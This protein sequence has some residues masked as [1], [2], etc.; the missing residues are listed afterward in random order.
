MNSNLLCVGL[1]GYLYDA[2][3]VSDYYA[4][5]SELSYDAGRPRLPSLG[6]SAA[7]SIHSVVLCDAIPVFGQSPTSSL[8]NARSPLKEGRTLIRLR[9]WEEPNQHMPLFYHLSD[10]GTPALHSE[11]R[12]GGKTANSRDTR[13][14]GHDQLTVRGMIGFFSNS[15][16]FGAPTQVDAFVKAVRVTDLEIR[17]GL[18]EH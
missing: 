11:R 16:L 17:A 4:G 2:L 6:D 1:A 15:L 18:P 7:P 10:A 14:E 5:Y 8:R 12:N 13:Q 3:N 9:S